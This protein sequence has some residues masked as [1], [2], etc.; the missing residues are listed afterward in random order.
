MASLNK[1]CV[2]TSYPIGTALIDNRCAGFI[3]RYGAQKG[4]LDSYL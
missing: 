1:M 4:D 3:N 2:V